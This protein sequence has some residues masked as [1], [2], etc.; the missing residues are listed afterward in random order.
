LPGSSPAAS[1]IAAGLHATVRLPET[2]DEDRI[3]AEAAARRDALGTASDYR[4]AP[5]RRPQLLLGYAT[6]PA[7][8]AGVRALRDAV[9]AAR[10]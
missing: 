3:V 5:G 1:S 10:A 4:V 9:E 2:D 6:Q 7:I 8:R